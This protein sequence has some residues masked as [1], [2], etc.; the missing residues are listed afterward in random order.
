MKFSVP[1]G[2]PQGPRAIRVSVAVT[3]QSIRLHFDSRALSLKFSFP[4]PTEDGGAICNSTSAIRIGTL[5]VL[6]FV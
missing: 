3:V 2:A 4:P 1:N 5:K 6:Q